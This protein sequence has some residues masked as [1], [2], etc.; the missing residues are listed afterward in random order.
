MFRGGLF[1]PRDLEVK[2]NKLFPKVA[3]FLRE[4]GGDGDAL[5]E[6]C[7]RRESCRQDVGDEASGIGVHRVGPPSTTHQKLMGS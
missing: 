6:E 5:G 3:I 2:L 4:T 1:S 7:R